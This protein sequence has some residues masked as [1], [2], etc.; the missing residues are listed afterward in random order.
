MRAHGPLARGTHTH[1]THQHTSS[2]NPDMSHVRNVTPE[3]RTTFRFVLVLW[4][5]GSTSVSSKGSMVYGL[6]GSM[7]YPKNSPIYSTCECSKG[8]QPL[9]PGPLNMAT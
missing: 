4:Y 7:L 1:E 3:H 6:D 5:G 8:H 2:A 9:A